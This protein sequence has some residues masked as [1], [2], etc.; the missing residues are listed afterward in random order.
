MYNNDHVVRIWCS[1]PMVYTW[2]FSSYHI[3]NLL[4]HF[5]AQSKGYLHVKLI[6]SILRYCTPG[7]LSALISHRILKICNILNRF[8][9]V[10]WINQGT[11]YNEAQTWTS[12]E[13]QI[14]FRWRRREGKGVW[15]RD[16]LQMRE[17]LRNTLAIFPRAKS[18]TW[19][20]KGSKKSEQPASYKSSSKLASSTR[21]HNPLWVR[22]AC[23]GPEAIFASAYQMGSPYCFHGLHHLGVL[24]TSVSFKFTSIHYLFRKK[25]GRK[26]ERKKRDNLHFLIQSQG[27]FIIACTSLIKMINECIVTEP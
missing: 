6:L 26:K 27:L 24:G 17:G 22:Y 9:F 25:K 23:P 7:L 18:I 21:R 20:E 3:G 12:L 4:S 15:L 5:L 11:L 1:S 16:Q 19:H 13:G 2:V 10:K 8:L 14:L